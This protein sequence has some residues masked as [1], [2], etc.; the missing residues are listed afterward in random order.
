MTKIRMTDYKPP[1]SPRA[2]SLL[3]GTG[4]LVAGAAMTAL[5]ATAIVASHIFHPGM[6]AV[7]GHMMS[8]FGHLVGLETHKL[9]VLAI[10]GGATI[11]GAVSTAVL[12]GR[13][14]NSWEKGYQKYL[15]SLSQEPYELDDDADEFL[16]NRYFQDATVVTDDAASDSDT[17]SSSEEEES[18]FYEYR[19]H[20][21]N[22][23]YLEVGEKPDPSWVLIEPW[24]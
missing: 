19:D 4:M 21:G 20:L 6:G 15:N 17:R 3:S 9:S 23:H 10:G 18:S 12:A 13:Y 11:G 2:A 1:L 24:I 5:V 8:H 14:F 16:S 22:S 7:S